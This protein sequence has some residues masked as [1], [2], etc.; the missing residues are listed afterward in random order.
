MKSDDAPTLIEEVDEAND[1][2]LQSGSCRGDFRKELV[3]E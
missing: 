3:D 1:A 2:L